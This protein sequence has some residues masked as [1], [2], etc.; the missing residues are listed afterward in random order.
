[1]LSTL[2]GDG[3]MRSA[4]IITDA[5]NLILS[6]NDIE[7][8]ENLLVIASTYNEAL[9]D[10]D[11]DKLSG[12]AVFRKMAW[13]FDGGRSS[14]VSIGRLREYLHER[15]DVKNTASQ[16]TDSS[17]VRGWRLTGATRMPCMNQVRSQPCCGQQKTPG[18]E[19][20]DGGSV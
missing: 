13:V 19:T 14:P 11:D 18:K 2:A 10:P 1:M 3:E 5:G 15:T 8:G 4:G 7:R 9:S 17:F 16:I 20:R 6:I 12:G